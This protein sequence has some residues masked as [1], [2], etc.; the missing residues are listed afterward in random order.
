MIQYSKATLDDLEFLIELR[1][2]DLKMFSTVPIQEETIKNIRYFLINGLENQ[3]CIT[4]LG[5]DKEVL[6]SS[7]TV[8]TYNVMPS[9]ENIKGIVG[10]FTNVWVD[11]RYRHQGIASQMVKKLILDL[12]DKVGMYCLNSSDEGIELYKKLGFQNKENYFVLYTK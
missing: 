2:R 5:Y 4:L 11:E 1:I 6:I 7:A 12:K 8:Y 9:N 10:Q 3:T